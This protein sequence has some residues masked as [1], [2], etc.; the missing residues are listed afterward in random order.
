MN[1]YNKWNKTV[2]NIRK[3][4]F[5]NLDVGSGT[6]TVSFVNA[7]TIDVVYLNVSQSTRYRDWETDRKSTRLNSSH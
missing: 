4:K 5:D 7:S 3:G 2:T 6:I 1:G